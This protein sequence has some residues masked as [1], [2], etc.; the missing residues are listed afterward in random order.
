MST[1]AF[2]RWA[3]YL[4]NPAR[5]AD[6]HVELRPE[7]EGEFRSEY[8]TLTGELLSLPGD[9]VPFYVW[10]PETNKWGIQRRVY[11]YGDRDAAPAL[12]NGVEI[13]EGRIRDG[14]HWRINHK[15]FI[16]ELFKYGFLIGDNSDRADEIRARIPETHLRSFEEGF[17]IMSAA[18][19]AELLLREQC[20]LAGMRTLAVSE[21]RRAWKNSHGD[22]DAALK[23][24]GTRKI[25][26]T[27]AKENALTYIPQAGA[28]ANEIESAEMRRA[29]VRESAPEKR[30]YLVETYARDHG[31]KRLA[32]KAFGEY[33]MH[34]ECDNTFIK[35]DGSRYI[36]VH[37]IVPLYK[38]GEDG[39]WNLSVLCAHHH[40]MAHFARKTERDKMRNFL[41]K[42]NEKFLSSGQ[43]AR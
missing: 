37:H 23:I 33:C 32:K 36:E 41:L 11:F 2:F 21:I 22:L 38:G 18:D 34:A 40:R 25:L 24:L 7:K 29:I 35:E 12:P 16:S 15:G 39:V 3:G 5:R 17:S 30:E 6:I 14:E 19:R 13:R 1:P 42:K 10:K 26:K 20:D 8:R 43:S 27:N 4:A 31:W 9:R 28:L